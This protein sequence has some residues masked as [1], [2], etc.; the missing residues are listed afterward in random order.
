M[1]QY[2]FTGKKN[3]TTQFKNKRPLITSKS[4]NMAQYKF[5]GKKKQ[6][7]TIK[8]KLKLFYLITLPNCLNRNNEVGQ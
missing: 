3:K 7:N 1:A 4:D 6:D 5:T 8:Q 2:K